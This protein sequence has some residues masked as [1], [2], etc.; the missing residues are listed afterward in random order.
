MKRPM[1]ILWSLVERPIGS[2]VASV[3]ADLGAWALG[4]CWDLRPATFWVEIG[5]LYAS[6]SRDE[7]WPLNLEEIPNW[8]VPLKRWVFEK[9]EIRLA[10]D[11]NA[12][13]I[14]VG[15]ADPYDWGLYCG[16]LNLQFEYDKRYADSR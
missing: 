4:F 12:W 16:P 11:W 8:T 2:W 6:I 7:P 9:L 14:G 1:K 10:I 3:D 13:L 15:M 5:P